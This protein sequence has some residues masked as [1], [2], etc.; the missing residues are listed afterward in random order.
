MALTA[1]TLLITTAVCPNNAGVSPVVPVPDNCHTIIVV[2]PTGNADVLMAQEAP[3][4]VLT[5]PGN[6]TRVPGGTSL[7]LEVGTISDRGTLSYSVP[8]GTTGFVYASGA[9]GVTCTI[10]YL[11]TF[12]PT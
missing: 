9:G 8:L 6:A 11:C 4:T 12:G 10:M 2:N 7:T 1:K 5:Q 3:G